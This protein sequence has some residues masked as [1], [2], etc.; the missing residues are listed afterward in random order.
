MRSFSHRRCAMLML[1][2]MGSRPMSSSL[3]STQML[4]P[5][6]RLSDR[7]GPAPPTNAAERSTHLA[8][9]L[10]RRPSGRWSRSSRVCRL[11]VPSQTSR[12]RW[13]AQVV[14]EGPQQPKE[15]STRLLLGE[16]VEVPLLETFFACVEVVDGG[17]CL[18]VVEPRLHLRGPEAHGC[19]CGCG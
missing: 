3:A 18:P 14:V 6:D 15:V 13:A 16:E 19:G 10:Q 9:V 4:A 17:H 5:F 12:R 7:M 11:G 8:E 2:S 1:K